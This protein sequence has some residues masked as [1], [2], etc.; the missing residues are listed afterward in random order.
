MDRNRFFPRPASGVAAVAAL[1]LSA[2]P[3]GAQAGG[4]AAHYTALAISM[5][6]PAGAAATPVDVIVQRWSTDEERDR[7][8][9]AILEAPD[10]IVSVLQKLPRVGTLRVPGSIGWDLRYAR[11]D[12]AENG[13]ERVTILTDR[14]V[15]FWEIT[16]MTRSREYPVTMMELRIGSNGQGEGTL[17]IGTK[18]KADPVTKTVIFENYN[19]QPVMLNG[20]RR[21]K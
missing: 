1:L 12:V 11:H 10:T 14:P 8:V 13:S 7:V 20:L 16:G 21:E 15:A 17:T 4:P 6:A 3:L 18:I 2:G 5:E 9:N 19:I